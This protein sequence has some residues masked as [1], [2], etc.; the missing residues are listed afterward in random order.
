[1]RAWEEFQQKQLPGINEQL[2]N[3]HRPLVNLNQKPGNMPEG[4]D[5]D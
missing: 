3:A 5:E 2:R 1:M 4:G